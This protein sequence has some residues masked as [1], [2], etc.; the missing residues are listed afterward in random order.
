MVLSNKYSEF[1]FSDISE[2]LMI[3]VRYTVR[4]NVPPWVAENLPSR[5]EFV[6]QAS[7]T[8]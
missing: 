1:C 8:L 4:V 6:L 7:Q 2:A 3:Q 5:N